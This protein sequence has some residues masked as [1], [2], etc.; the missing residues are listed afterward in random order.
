MQN[1]NYS[2]ARVLLIVMVEDQEIENIDLPEV[3]KEG[4]LAEISK[5]NSGKSD[6][7]IRFYQRIDTI[8]TLFGQDAIYTSKILYGSSA[9]CKTIDLD[10]TSENYITVNQNK[11]EKLVRELLLN[12]RYIV[13]L[14]KDNN[15]LNP[16][17]QLIGRGSP[18]NLGFFEEIV[19]NQSNFVDSGVICVLYI[20]TSESG[21]K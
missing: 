7:C 11:F 4:F 6:M 9:S 16:G 15:K 8:Y 10:N 3:E 17:F 5:F 2:P 19:Y 13:E 21:V 1:K 12:K 14:Y 18:G 20:K